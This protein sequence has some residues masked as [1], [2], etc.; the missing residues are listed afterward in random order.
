M[1][2]RFW[3]IAIFIFGIAFGMGWY[4]RDLILFSEGMKNDVALLDSSKM[5]KM[6]L[7]KEI[8]DS[9][10]I[11]RSI[12]NQLILNTPPDFINDE[13]DEICNMNF[14]YLGIAKTKLGVEFRIATLSEDIGNACR[15]TTRVLI[16]GQNFNYLGNYYTPNILPTSLDQNTLIG[17]DLNSV[18]LSNGIPDSAQF[19]SGIWSVFEK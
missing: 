18:D 12:I 17:Q 10:K 1:S 4:F 11:Q 3:I 15:N 8:I 7:P 2:S 9:F 5:V 16:Y 19:I 14:G 6:V 13:D